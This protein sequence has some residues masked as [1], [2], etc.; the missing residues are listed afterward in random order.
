MQRYTAKNGIEH[1]RYYG[2]LFLNILSVRVDSPFAFWCS[3]STKFVRL[4]QVVAPFSLHVDSGPVSESFY[5]SSVIGS[6]Q[7]RASGTRRAH[8]SCLLTQNQSPKY[9]FTPMN[10]GFNFVMALNLN[11]GC[12]IVQVVACS[13]LTWFPTDTALTPR[14]DIAA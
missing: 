8:S 13:Q 1:R 10:L 14:L 6:T 11:F 9:T 12:S 3:G 7:P 4:L 5:G 2:T